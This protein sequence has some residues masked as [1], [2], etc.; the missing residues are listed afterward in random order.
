MNWGPFYME[1]RWDQVMFSP[2]LIDKVKRL[3][4]LFEKGLR[5]ETFKGFLPI[6]SWRA[7]ISSYCH[8]K[9]PLTF[10]LI[11][12]ILWFHYSCNSH[13]QEGRHLEEQSAWLHQWVGK[14]VLLLISYH[15]CTSPVFSLAARCYHKKTTNQLVPLLRQGCIIWW[16]K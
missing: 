5:I 14:L 6:L 9:I 3:P 16:E 10:F 11:L 1:M 12:L 4:R 15:H 7:Q 8:W 13:F 2:H